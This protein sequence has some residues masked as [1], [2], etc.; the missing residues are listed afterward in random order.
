MLPRD[1]LTGKYSKTAPRRGTLAS[2]VLAAS[3][4]DVGDPDN[5]QPQATPTIQRHGRQDR[6]KNQY[7]YD[8]NWGFAGV[9]TQRCTDVDR[10]AALNAQEGITYDDNGTNLTL[11]GDA[12]GVASDAET[13][14]PEVGFRLTGT[15]K[16][17]TGPHG[18]VQM[19]LGTDTGTGTTGEFFND[20]STMLARLGDAHPRAGP[21]P[22]H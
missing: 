12:T 2:L 15:V 10:L 16:N 7:Y 8:T 14:V 4:D 3:R 11:G 1:H 5:V 18:A 6:V 17:S 21:V 19:C 13:A 22:E 9:S 20:L